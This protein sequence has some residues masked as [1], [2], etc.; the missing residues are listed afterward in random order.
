[1]KQ[2]MIDPVTR[3]EGHAKISIHLDDDGRV[4]GTQLHVTQIRGFEKFTEGRPFYEM[5]GI[6]SRICGICPV[7]HLLASS[8]AC[9]AIMA[10]RIPSVA[11]Q[12]RELLHCAQFVQSHAL[13]F[14][15][16]SSP[17]LLLGMDSDAAKRN[18]LGVIEKHPE[19]ARLGIELRKFGLQIIEGL[20]QERVHP[21]WVVPG[22]V[23][24]PMLPQT[25]DRI[26]A[27][28]PMAIAGTE[29]AISFFK[30]AID[31]FKEEI[32]YFGT[33]P[34][35]YAGTVDTAGTL[36]LYE[37]QLRFKRCCRADRQWW[38]CCRGI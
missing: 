29:R 13:S 2:L 12:L 24:A 26:A 33:A 30:S 19:L 32:E 36:Q 27:E 7:S 5:P 10:V 3:I 8:K 22:G 11:R 25:R 35:M 17:D 31:S 18:V 1:M 20:A 21:S 34:T 16:L 38:S 14:F 15:Y 28:L 4:V 37:G 9:D 23:N 6:T